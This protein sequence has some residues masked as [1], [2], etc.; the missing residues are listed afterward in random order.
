MKR[1]WFFVTLAL[2][3]SVVMLGA[4]GENL[5]KAFRP[6]RLQPYVYSNA[7]KAL[8]IDRIAGQDS[9]I[10]VTFTQNLPRG[11]SYNGLLT[12]AAE[13]DTLTSGTNT[14]DT[15]WFSLE[16]LV[17]GRWIDLRDTILWYRADLMSTTAQQLILPGHHGVVWMFS[18]VPD[19]SLRSLDQY[20]MD[21]YRLNVHFDDNQNTSRFDLKTWASFY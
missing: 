13:V 10:N 14:P 11:T 5:W 2:A 18:T 21:D 9:S 20:V 7:R 6:S 17:G 8:T 15:V 16:V 3:L 4:T 12:L 19:T 1:S